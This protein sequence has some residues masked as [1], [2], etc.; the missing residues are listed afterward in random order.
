MSLHTARNV[1]VHLY[2]SFQLRLL[3]VV[4]I[5]VQLESANF[6]KICNCIFAFL[7]HPV[8]KQLV[9]VQDYANLL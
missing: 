4:S 5:S 1:I 3:A 8:G 7:A 2:N 9:Y 6:L